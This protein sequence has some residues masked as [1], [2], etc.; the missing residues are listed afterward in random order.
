MRGSLNSI[1]K[2]II[3][4]KLLANCRNRNSI[5]TAGISN[6]LQIPCKQPKTATA[7]A[8]P[9]LAISSKTAVNRLK[10]HLHSLFLPSK[11]HQNRTPL[12]RSVLPSKTARSPEIRYTHACLKLQNLIPHWTYGPTHHQK[13][14]R[15]QEISCKLAKTAS[16]FAL[17]ELAISSKTAVNRLKQH[18]HSLFRNPHFYEVHLPSKWHHLQK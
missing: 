10:H 17:L 7:L 2:S 4:S 13:G 6:L 15:F 12:L 18:L 9:G 3:S 16:A 5:C 14:C 11:T 8:L 1:R